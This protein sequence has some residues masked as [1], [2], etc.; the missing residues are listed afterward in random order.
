MHRARSHQVKVTG[1]RPVV[2][3][4]RA[5]RVS[6]VLIAQGAKGTDGLREVALAAGEAGVTVRR[7]PRREL[8]RL[9]SDHRGV[10]AV[11]TGTSEY[12]GEELGES[13]IARF[14]FDIDASV[15][16]LDGV[17]DPQNLGAA[18]RVADAAGAAMLVTRVKRAAGVT[19]AAVRA[20]A[21]ALLTLP[22][23]RVA[24][25]ARALERLK[26]AGFTVA[27]LDAAA[28]T[29][30]ER[31]CPD[32]R[33]AIVVGSEGSGLSRLVSEACDLLVSLPM[34]G[35]VESLN[36]SASLAAAMFSWIVPRGVDS[37]ETPA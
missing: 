15:V 3:A 25:I 32:G 23:A 37:G 8:D 11:L 36:A 2:E 31:P 27:G 22:H 33:V 4:L 10:I 7:V 24:N 13:D 29:V 12:L 21:G 26:D 5:G 14:P 20:S 28:P 17:T 35:Q 18:A 6:E 16:V 1:K 34:R 30:F 19:D 9:A